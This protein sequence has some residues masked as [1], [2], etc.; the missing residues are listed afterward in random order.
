MIL[1]PIKRERN[2]LRSAAHLE[3]NRELNKIRCKESYFKR[4]EL[5][6]K[7]RDLLIEKRGYPWVQAKD[8][9]NGIKRRC[10]KPAGKNACYIG[11][12]VCERW[13][14]SFD[15]FLADMGL[16]AAGESIDR[17]D[18]LEGY[19]P[20]NCR[21][22]NSTVQARN[23]RYPKL[24]LEDARKIRAAHVL[25]FTSAQLGRAFNVSW[26]TIDTLLSNETWKENAV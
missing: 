1:D 17:I 22:V 21:W 6:G 24:S 18:V 12:K 2:R 13:L 8:A 25:G 14:A 9:W 11:V 4:K 23:R 19:E 10:E 7:P 16:P 15:D 20:G 26:T 5:F 3:K